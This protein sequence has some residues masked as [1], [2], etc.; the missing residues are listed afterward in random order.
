MRKDGK[1]LENTIKLIEEAYKDSETTQIFRNH[2][3]KDVHGSDREIDVLIKINSNGYEIN[4]AIEC[5]DYQQRV[6]PLHV[7]AFN[8]KC[9]TIKEINKMILVSSN[10][11]Q[12]TAINNAKLFGIELMTAE[13]LSAE[14]L[15]NLMP[16]VT[17][18][19]IQ[20]LQEFEKPLLIFDTSD[21]LFLNEVEASFIGFFTESDSN[22]QVHINDI[23]GNGINSQGVQIQNFALMNYIKLG[24]TANDVIIPADIN[25]AFS[26]RLYYL[27]DSAE[28]KVY[29][30]N[31]KCEIKI[32]INKAPAETFGRVIKKS[33]ESI[34]AHS[35]KFK[36]ADNAESELIIKDNNDY[37]IYLTDNKETIKLE[38]L[39]AYDPKTKKFTKS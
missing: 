19:N 28:N 17:Q 4:I 20:V 34:K 3:M 24:T 35:L 21:K 11:F 36:M 12:K 7:E 29:L 5:K 30:L 16:S 18:L 2:K 15:K 38:K 14:Y 22:K 31:I 13:E 32:S 39:L 25:I 33:N 8:S 1:S 23:I 6:P 10:G 9:S 27:T 26:K 37:A